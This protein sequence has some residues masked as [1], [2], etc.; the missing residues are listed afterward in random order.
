LNNW[1]RGDWIVNINDGQKSV[2]YKGLI[3]LFFVCMCVSMCVCVCDICQRIEF[4]K[5]IICTYNLC[6]YFFLHQF[7]AGYHLTSRAH[8]RHRI[9][10]YIDVWTILQ[11]CTWCQGLGGK[12]TRWPCSYKLFLL[13]KHILEMG[14]C[15]Q[16]NKHTHIQDDGCVTRYIYI[17]MCV[18]HL[19]KKFWCSY[20]FF[21]KYPRVENKH[22]LFSNIG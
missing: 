8:A 13:H 11:I 19:S 1:H 22:N 10:A 17:Y 2:T 4:K 3:S 16:R 12:E 14:W 18:W 15:V 6:S 9:P 21:Y 7:G 5:K 20:V